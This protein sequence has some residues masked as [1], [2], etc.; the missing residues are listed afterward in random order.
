[1]IKRIWKKGPFDLSKI[2]PEYPYF[3][4]LLALAIA[5]IKELPDFLDDDKI[6][7]MSDFSGEHKGACFNTYTF[8]IYSQT[9]IG[10]FEFKVK[11]LRRKYGILD[12]YSEFAYKDLKYGPR[13][14]ALAEYLNLVDS[15]IHGSLITV[16]IDRNIDTVFGLS[17]KDTFPLI[18]QQL[19]AQGFGAWS[20]AMGEKV[21]R[22]CHSIA[23]FTSLV[24]RENHKLLWYCDLDPIN[25]DGKG[26]SFSDTQKLFVQ[27]LGMYTKHRFEIVGFC[28]SF[29][30]KSYL[31]DLLSIADFGAGVVQDILQWHRLG[32]DSIPGS[33]EKEL[34]LKW[35]TNK[36]E[37]LSK[38]TVEICKLENGEIGSGVVEFNPAKDV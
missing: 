38:I 23:L 36:G 3:S 27:I 7:V 6:A 9:K 5:Q 14:R 20:G 37:H 24:S 28:K 18:E 10:L 13:S 2:T 21:L 8:L 25:D 17:K 11:E 32:A 15:F 31:D 33:D 29:D 34:V 12:P 30:G 22:V 4:Q 16:A 26:R 35:I 19:L 1:M